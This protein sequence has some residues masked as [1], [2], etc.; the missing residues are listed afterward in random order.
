MTSENEEAQAK[1][2]FMRAVTAIHNKLVSE[3]ECILTDMQVLSTNPG[4]V[5]DFSRR[6]ENKLAELAAL[7][8]KI[9]SI[10]SSFSG[11]PKDGGEEKST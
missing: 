4:S 9:N 11:N 5:S 3:K 6:V 7:D 8:S 10:V 1:D 2:P